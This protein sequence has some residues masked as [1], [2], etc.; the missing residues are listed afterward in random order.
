MQCCSLQGN[1][2]CRRHGWQPVGRISLLCST[3]QKTKW[4][5]P[6]KTSAGESQMLMPARSVFEAPS[7]YLGKVCDSF[8]HS[9]L[10]SKNW[11]IIRIWWCI[12]RAKFLCSLLWLDNLENLC[13]ELKI[14][15]CV[16]ELMDLNFLVHIII[17]ILTCGPQANFKSISHLPLWWITATAKESFC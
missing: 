13:S 10:N 15:P 11:Y 2:R 1:W 3:P 5:W 8:F 12:C 14:K 9:M 4:K 17:F 16:T 6:R 7:P